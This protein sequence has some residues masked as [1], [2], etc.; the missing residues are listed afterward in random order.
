MGWRSI[1]KNVEIIGTIT[2]QPGKK[3]PVVVGTV[4]KQ[5][6]RRPVDFKLKNTYGMKNSPAHTSATLAEILEKINAKI[7]SVAPQRIDDFTG[8]H[9]FI[10]S[11]IAPILAEFDLVYRT[12]YVTPPHNYQANFFDLNIDLT[13]DKRSKYRRGKLN[14]LFFG[15]CEPYNPEMTVDNAIELFRYNERAAAIERLTAFIDEQTAAIADAKK[16]ISEYQKQQQQFK[17]KFK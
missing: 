9:H 16:Q 8:F 10:R 17:C 2:I 6:F 3:R 13:E 11:E 4:G 1:G 5:G 12:W 14:D 15:I 7:K